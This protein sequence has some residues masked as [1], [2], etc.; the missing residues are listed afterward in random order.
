MKKTEKLLHTGCRISRRCMIPENTLHFIPGNVQLDIQ[1]LIQIPV[2]GSTGKLPFGEGSFFPIPVFYALPFRHI[3][4]SYAALPPTAVWCYAS[5]RLRSFR[6]SMLLSL[7][8]LLFSMQ[9]FYK[10]VVSKSI[11]VQMALNRYRKAANFLKKAAPPI[12]FFP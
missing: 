2:K 5:K 9:T 6:A 11:T 1:I 12:F 10:T 8:S 4:F 7:Y 3:P